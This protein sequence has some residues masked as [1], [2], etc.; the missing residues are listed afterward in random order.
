MY[1]NVILTILVL[2]LI[3]IS[4]LTVLWWKKYGKELFSLIIN[5]KNM[6][7]NVSSSNPMLPDLNSLLSDFES[8]SK[9]FSKFGNNKN[10]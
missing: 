5:M 9:N 3:T 6:K 7:E 10:L 4:T 8:I 2:V 1:L